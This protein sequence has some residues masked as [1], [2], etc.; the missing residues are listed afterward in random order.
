MHQLNDIM[1]TTNTIK[2]LL[3][4]ETKRARITFIDR[5]DD[6]ST[7]LYSPMYDVIHLDEKRFYI[8]RASQ[9]IYLSLNEPE[10]LRYVCCLMMLQ[11]GA[12]C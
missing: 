3:T 10:P 2:P 4:E 1:D 6:E 5:F 8:T 9:R 11:T 7:L 12:Q